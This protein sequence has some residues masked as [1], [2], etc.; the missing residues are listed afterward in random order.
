MVDRIGH[1]SS[2]LKGAA[3]VFALVIPPPNVTGSLHIGHAGA[4]HREDFSETFANRDGYHL[5]ADVWLVGIL[6]VTLYPFFGG[7]IWRRYWYPLAKMMQIVQCGVYQVSG[8]PVRHS[9]QRKCIACGECSRNCQ[10]GI[11]VM[12]FAMKQE[13]LNNFNSSCIGCGICVSVCPM[14]VLSFARQG[15]MGW[16]SWRGP[17]DPR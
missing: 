8:Q 11:D 3:A 9:R 5:F 10:V 4:R 6:P 14:D 2:V 15:G 1:F 13:E 16:C 17:R 7:K 12:N